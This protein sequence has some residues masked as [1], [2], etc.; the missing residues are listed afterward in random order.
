MTRDDVIRMAREAGFSQYQLGGMF[1][2]YLESFAY[3]AYAAG[4]ASEREASKA[5]QLET[6]ALREELTKRA[7]RAEKEAYQRGVR[8]ER[9]VCAKVVE[10]TDVEQFTYCQV[11]HDDGSATLAN[12]AASIR[13]RNNKDNQQ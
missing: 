10:D 7:M 6:I 4:Q 12:A 11:L 1:D 2:V 13:A 3:A 8:D 9:E 5:A